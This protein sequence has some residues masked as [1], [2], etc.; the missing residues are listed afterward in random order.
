[1]RR[2]EAEPT[3]CF[4]FLQCFTVFST[5][6]ISFTIGSRSVGYKTKFHTIELMKVHASE[7]KLSAIL[8]FI[9][10]NKPQTKSSR[11]N[12]VV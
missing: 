6:E 2:N 1:M 10:K 4:F 7:H 9:K 8:K 11:N 5:T 3:K 12:T